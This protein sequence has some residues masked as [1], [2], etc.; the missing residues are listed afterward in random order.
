[1]CYQG[2]QLHYISSVAEIYGVVDDPQNCPGPIVTGII[3][4]RKKYPKNIVIS[5]TAEEQK[6]TRNAMQLAK[7]L[8]HY[9]HEPTK[10]SFEKY[11]G[12]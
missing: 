7:I 8:A 1:M 5:L 2:E 6:N 4:E 11:R 10:L 12:F 3:E 9:K